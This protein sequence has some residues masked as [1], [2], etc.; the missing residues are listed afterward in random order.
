MKKIVDSSVSC[1]ICGSSTLIIREMT[2]EFLT[3]SLEKHFKLKVTANLQIPS[4][5]MI[6]CR[7]CKVEFSNPMIPGSPNFYKWITSLDGYYPKTRWEYAPAFK[8]IFNAAQI[9]SV[10][11][12]DVGC[13]SGD[14]LLRFKGIESIEAIG[15]DTNLDSV[16][17]CLGRGVSA[18]CGTVEDFKNKN[19]NKLFDF[20]VSFHCIEHVPDPKGFI[21]EMASLLKPDGVLIVSAPLSPMFFELGWFDVLNYPP[22]HLSRFSLTSID[23]LALNSDLNVNVVVS[24]SHSLLRAAVISLIVSELS[25]KESLS[26]VEIFLLL[27]KKF[28]LFIFKYL[29]LLVNSFAFKNHRSETFLASFKK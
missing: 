18:V 17:S 28:P 24:P 9:K 25:S 20:I 12:L 27:I 10:S 26:R 22:H 16:Q 15:L 6:K 7:V 5:Q 11:V 21:K 23:A 1:I 8:K 19:L 14:F 29:S 4:Y 13:G 2:S 3:S